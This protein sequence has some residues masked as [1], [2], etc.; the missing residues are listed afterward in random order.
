MTAFYTKT[1]III[2]DGIFSRAI[3]DGIGLSPL[4]LVRF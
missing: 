2:I 1:G 4:P 3:I